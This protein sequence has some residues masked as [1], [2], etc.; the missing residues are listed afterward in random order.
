MQNEP[1][2]NAITGRP[3]TAL[4]RVPLT[5]RVCERDECGYELRPQR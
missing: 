2:I 4:G 1:I 5:R 3:R